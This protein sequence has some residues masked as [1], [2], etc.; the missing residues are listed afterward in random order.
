[1]RATLV[2]ILSAT[3]LLSAPGSA[4]LA[5]MRSATHPRG[6]LAQQPDP[7][8]REITTAIARSAEDETITLSASFPDDA[9]GLRVALYNMI[10]RLIHVH[11]VS[12]VEKGDYVFRFQTAGLPTGPY[13]IVLEANGQRI[14]NKVMLSR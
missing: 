1:M 12:S 10:G 3:L 8:K 14:V 4:A 9:P 2:I 6:E 7:K 11:P 13:I 5:S